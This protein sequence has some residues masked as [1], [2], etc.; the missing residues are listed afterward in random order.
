MGGLENATAISIAYL[1]LGDAAR[2][3]YAIEF[4]IRSLLIMPASSW[5][6]L[7]K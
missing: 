7:P 5:Q 3:R 1:T 4:S 6:N 2:R